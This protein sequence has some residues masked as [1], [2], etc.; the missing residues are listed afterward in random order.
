MTTKITA[1]I[2]ISAMQAGED[3]AKALKVGDE[4][5]GAFGAA[6]VMGFYDDEA[7]RGL[8]THGFLKVIDQRFPRGV[9]CDGNTGCIVAEA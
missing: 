3:A 7:Q 6:R 1:A 4:F 9:P 2:L 8:F 5:T